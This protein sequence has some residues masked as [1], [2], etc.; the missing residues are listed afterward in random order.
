MRKPTLVYPVTIQ[1]QLPDDRKY[2]GY[3]EGK[4]NPV[5]ILDLRRLKETVIAYLMH[6]PLCEAG[7]KFMGH[8]EQNYTPRLGRFG[9]SNIG[10]LFSVTMA[11]MME[12]GS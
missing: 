12:R 3:G 6:L 10:N 8:S 9:N 11:N 2:Q 4:W 1:E 5:D 7:T